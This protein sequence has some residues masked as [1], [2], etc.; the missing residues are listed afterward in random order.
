MLYMYICIRSTR[1][2]YKT[3]LWN[4]RESSKIRTRSK[5]CLRD[6][7]THSLQLLRLT[8]FII[9]ANKML[10]CCI[11][12]KSHTRYFSECAHSRG[13]TELDLDQPVLLFARVCVCV[14]YTP[15]SRISVRITRISCAS[16]KKH[17]RTH[18]L[19]RQMRRGRWGKQRSVKLAPTLRP[20]STLYYRVQVH[21]TKGKCNRFYI[22]ITA[23]TSFM[24]LKSC[25]FYL[26]KLSSY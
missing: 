6:A 25:I 22:E 19:G 26:H 1:N 24:I 20:N 10:C 11:I 4:V 16:H 3:L 18:S 17:T 15:G 12:Y 21:E 23:W 8:S 5:P 2:V 14:W 7:H 9:H 13:H